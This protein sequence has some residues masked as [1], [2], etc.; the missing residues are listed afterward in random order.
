MH[1]NFN[2]NNYQNDIALIHL[3]NEVSYNNYVQPACLWD[4]SNRTNEAIGTVI[5]WGLTETDTVGEVLNQAQM[6]IVPS[7]KCLESNRNVFSIT[8]GEY[9]FCA[10]YRNGE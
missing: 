6:P 2:T 7:I 8:L 5:G 10:G 9:N 1:E 3:A 4:L